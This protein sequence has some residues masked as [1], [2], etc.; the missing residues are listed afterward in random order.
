MTDFARTG[1]LGIGRLGEALAG[2]ILAL[3]DQEKLLVGRRS[4]AR[5]T[6]L[7]TADSRVFSADVDEIVQNCDHLIIALRPG[8]ARELLPKLRFAPRHQII[9]LMA[10]IGLDE[11]RNLTAGAGSVCRLLALPSVTQGGQLLPCYPVTPVA[12]HLFGRR[13]QLIEAANEDELMIFWTITGLLSSV[14]AMGDAAARWLQS[15]GIRHDI[16][17]AYARGLFSEVHGL[18]GQGFS[19]GLDEVSTPNGLNM[20]MREKM[21]EVGMDASIAAGLDEIHQRLCEAMGRVAAR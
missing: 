17:E 16:A 10:E 12:A 18:A 13:N 4:A 19:E 3:P 2:A 15:A 21:S 11:L 5:V 9:S 7:T 20:M 1:I 6:R 14:M 8:D